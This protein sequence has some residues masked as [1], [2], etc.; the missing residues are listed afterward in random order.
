MSRKSVI[1]IVGHLLRRKDRGG[2]AEVVGIEA[3]PV[4]LLDVVAA[5]ERDPAAGV[6]HLAADIVVLL[7]NEH[8][9]AQIAG[10]YRRLR[11]TP[12]LPMTTTS[13]S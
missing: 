10:A 3:E 8:R 4:A 5:A 7:E 2:E 13:T 11:P 12:P 1:R 9:G 6:A